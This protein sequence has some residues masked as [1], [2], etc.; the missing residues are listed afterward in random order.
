VLV[1]GVVKRNAQSLPVQIAVDGIESQPEQSEL[2]TIDEMS[3]LVDDLIGDASL[4]EY[5]EDIRGG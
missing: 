3:G 1:H 5:M 4:A 2:P